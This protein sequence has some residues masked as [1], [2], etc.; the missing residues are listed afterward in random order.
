M[1]LLSELNYA[2]SVQKDVETGKDLQCWTV[3][4]SQ[5]GSLNYSRVGD[6]ETARVTIPTEI[7]IDNTASPPTMTLADSSECPVT[8][9][10]FI[11]SLQEAM[12]QG[13]T[14]FV[15]A[16][17]DLPCPFSSGYRYI[18][19]SACER[20][21]GMGDIESVCWTAARPTDNPLGDPMSRF[22]GTIVPITYTMSRPV[23]FELAPEGEER[24]KQEFAGPLI[25]SGTRHDYS[26]H[27]VFSKRAHAR[28]WGDDTN[29]ENPRLEVYAR[30]MNF[31]QGC[32]D[33]VDESSTASEITVCS[34]TGDM[35]R[36]WINS[37][38]NQR[39][40]SLRDLSGVLEETKLL[41][42]PTGG[43]KAMFDEYQ[44]FRNRQNKDNQ[45]RPDLDGESLWRPVS[46][47]T[48][49]KPDPVFMPDGG[50]WV[51]G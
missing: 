14:S 5:K 15:P 25:R 23:T 3:D 34:Q 45:G 44:S 18:F 10:Q 35:K 11:A 38:F 43:L 8:N 28:V 40:P 42:L 47:I 9:P 12:S 46:L 26:N 41:D 49:V 48:R 4:G 29:D 50:S 36:G 6:S 39:N 22:G 17:A 27:K 20:L 33:S 24:P 13:E 2:D 32:F 7:L 30:H 51:E 19:S 21:S 1:T 16:T 31:L 37:C